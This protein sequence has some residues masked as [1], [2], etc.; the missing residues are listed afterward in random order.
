MKEYLT[1]LIEKKETFLEWTYTTKNGYEYTCNIRRSSGIGS[2]CGY[3]RLT[4]DSKLYGVSYD[5]IYDIVNVIVHGGLTYSVEVI[6]M[7]G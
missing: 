1:K 3:V 6:K 7:I 5:N 4:P 2:L